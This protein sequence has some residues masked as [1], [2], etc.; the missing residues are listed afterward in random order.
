MPTKQKAILVYRKGKTYA[1][2]VKGNK[3]K[4]TRSGQ[5]ERKTLIK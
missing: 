1:A 3:R 4:E 5:R 2:S